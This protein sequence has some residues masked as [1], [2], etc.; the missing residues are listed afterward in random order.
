MKA[1]FFFP[2]AWRHSRPDIEIP[3]LM[4]CLRDF[5]IT[6]CDLN[7]QYRIYQRGRDNLDECYARIKAVTSESIFEK[8]DMIYY[9]L[10]TNKVRVEYI[11]HEMEHFINIEE[12]ARASLYERELQ[13]FHKTAYEKDRDI[14][15]WNSISEIT[16][17]IE[18]LENEDENYY[19]AFYKNY[20]AEHDLNGI[21][22]VLIYPAGKQQ[23]TA[24]FTLCR[25]I[26]K[27]NPAIKII[28]GGQPFRDMADEIDQSWAP[29]FEKL[30]DYVM[31][32]AGEQAVCELLSCVMRR[33]NAASVDGCIYK[34]DENVIKNTMNAE[35]L[36]KNVHLPDFGGFYL[37]SY[38]VPAI[39]L[40]YCVARVCAH[41]EKVIADLW[42]Y[43]EKYGA[44][45]VYFVDKS[46]SFDVIAQLCH[47]IL[48]EGLNI[49]WFLSSP[50]S[51][52]YTAELLDL[53]KKAGAVLLPEFKTGFITDFYNTCIFEEEHMLFMISENPHFL[54]EAYLKRE[55]MEK[56][57]D[58]D[59]FVLEK[60][61]DETMYQ[62]SLV[63]QEFN[64]ITD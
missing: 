52:Q 63:T 53:M 11:L 20:F 51:G 27:H 9:F 42:L 40:P 38:N 45:Y 3:A 43:Q 44:E 35:I 33:K 30:F 19:L 34:Q 64:I 59:D 7:V 17:D 31:I 12:Y 10:I 8:Y 41:I 2:P 29:F 26:R 37:P 25:Y 58:N 47:A 4:P 14:N 39:T 62:Y 5:D 57:E 16:N 1:V 23:L 48:G 13:L 56:V 50:I 46:L 6:V 61:I 15:V 18:L 36:T 60:I 21:D 32:S 28:V 54:D 49:R 22:V 24:V 55:Y